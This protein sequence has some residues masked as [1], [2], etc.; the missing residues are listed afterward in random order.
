MPTI[1]EWME[2]QGEF[3]RYLECGILAHGFA[4]VVPEFVFDQRLGW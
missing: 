2:S 1:A 4:R 3:H